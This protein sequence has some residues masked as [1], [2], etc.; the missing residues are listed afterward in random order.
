MAPGRGGALAAAVRVV[1]GVHGRAARLRAHAHVALA[2][3]LAHLD[4]LVIGVADR[5]DGR[6]ALV[7]DHA[8]LARGQAQGRHAGVLGHELD[9]G[10]GGAAHLPAAAR[11]ELDVVDDGAGGDPG[12]RQGVARADLRGVTRHHRRADLQARR[13]QDVGLHAVGVVQQRDVRGPVGVVLDRGDL[14]RD[15]VAAAL[16]VDD[17]VQALG[18]AAAVAGGLAA[19]AV[20]P[21]RLLQALDER[22]LGLALRDLGEVGVGDEPLAGAGRPG[23]AD[24]HRLGL[25]EALQALEDRDGLPRRDL[26]DGLLPRPRAAGRVPAP[27]GLGLHGHRADLDHVDLEELLDGLADLRLVGAGVHP[28]RVLV[29]RREDVALLADDRADDDLAGVHQALASSGCEFVAPAGAVVAATPVFCGPF[30]RAVS[31]SMAAWLT[32]TLAAPTRSA[33]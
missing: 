26:H 11:L 12:E 24:G 25:L 10:P 23:L 14:R 19:V 3:G 4:V 32:R 15:A 33:T 6:P 1:D 8:H 13:G 20:A 17:A 21:A 31:A 18:P 22:A 28:E 16:E 7:A 27:L 5:A 30:A 29:R 2:A 9:G